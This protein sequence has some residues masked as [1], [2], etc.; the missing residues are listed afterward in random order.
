[1]TWL[2]AL[3]NNNTVNKNNTSKDRP[4]GNENLSPD[5][6]FRWLGQWTRKM[7]SMWTRSFWWGYINT[8]TPKI[9]GN[10][11]V[12]MLALQ[13]RFVGFFLF[14]IYRFWLLWL[15]VRSTSLFVLAGK[16]ARMGTCKVQSAV[17]LI[18]IH[19]QMLL[20][21]YFWRRLWLANLS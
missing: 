3:P 15:S 7:L 12:N 11:L 10:A 6:C 19:V 21:S 20:W 9:L 5:M 16:Q 8:K 4:A 14:F 1:M 18:P 17:R 2:H 13:R